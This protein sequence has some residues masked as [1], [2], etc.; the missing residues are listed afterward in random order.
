MKSQLLAMV[1]ILFIWEA[2][3]SVSVRVLSWILLTKEMF[4]LKYK[5]L[6]VPITSYLKDLNS[7]SWARIIEW[8]L[9]SSGL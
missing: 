3:D 1:Y 9:D 4:I 2:N 8:R 5:F 7:E 6:D